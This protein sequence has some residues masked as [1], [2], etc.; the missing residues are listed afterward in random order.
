[1]ACGERVWV[2][3]PWHRLPEVPEGALELVI[4]PGLAFGTGQHPTTRLCLAAMEQT[5]DARPEAAAGLRTLD[6]G[7]GS[8]IL[9]LYA[10]LRGATEI[11]AIDNDPLAVEAA[12]ENFRLNLAIHRG[13]EEGQPLPDGLVISGTP[14]ADVAETGGPFDLIVANILLDPLVE[15]A[16]LLSGLLAPGGRMI[17]SGILAVQSD[18]LWQAYSGRLRSIAAPATATRRAE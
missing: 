5:F 9:A 10:A 8:G 18:E 6:L 4:D 3:P 7:T 16:P 1:L 15:L 11:T 2:S 14:I 17:L 12:E 13:L